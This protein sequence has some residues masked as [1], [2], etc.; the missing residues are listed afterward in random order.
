MFNTETTRDYSLQTFNCHF[1]FSEADA[2]HLRE[3]P[4]LF[5]TDWTWLFSIKYSYSDTKW[6]SLTSITYTA[7]PFSFLKHKVSWTV[8]DLQHTYF[9][10]CL[11][12]LHRSQWDGRREN[13][14]CVLS[15]Y[16]TFI[17]TLLVWDTYQICHKPPRSEG[18]PHKKNNNNNNNNADWKQYRHYNDITCGWQIQQFFFV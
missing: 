13:I 6:S 9:H 5:W 15:A 17:Q 4:N 1:Q 16:Q 2:K 14:C 12:M 8:L 3:K 11:K 10:L 7:L 18:R